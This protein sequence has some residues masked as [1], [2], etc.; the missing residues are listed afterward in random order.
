MEN[1]GQVARIFIAKSRAPFAGALFVQQ[2]V[3]LARGNVR[4]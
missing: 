2:S 1:A 3:D 4:K